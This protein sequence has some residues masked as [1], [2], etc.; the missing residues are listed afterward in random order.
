MSFESIGLAWPYSLFWLLVGGLIYFLCLFWHAGKLFK[1][2]TTKEAWKLTLLRAL[3]GLFFIL[4]VARP[5]MDNLKTNPDAVRIVSLI[6]LS[7]SMNQRDAPTETRRIELVQPWFNLERE[8][9]WINKLR[10]RFGMVDRLGFTHDEVFKVRESSWALPEMGNNTSLGDAL[11]YIIESPDLGN[12]GAVV[13]FSD[14]RNN[15]G[16]SPLKTGEIF[17][18]RGIPVNIIGVGKDRDL[19][20]ISVA[21]ADIPTDVN[22][23]EELII[24]AEIQNSFQSEVSTM[25][26]LLVN[27]LE[28]ESLSVS[29]G[30]GESRTIRFPPLI[31]EVP[32]VFTYRVLV[33]PLDGDFDPSDDEDAQL[34]QVRPPS[35]FSALYLSHQ[36]RPLYPFLKRALSNERFQLSSLIRLGNETFHARGEKILPTGYPNNP[37]FWMDY[38]VVLVD[39]G[40]LN[41][42]NGTLVT[43]L[44]D[45]VQKRGGGL[46]LLGDPTPAQQ[47]LGGLMPVKQTQSAMAKEDLSLSVSPD[48]LF[49]E[50]K[51]LDEWKTFL[52]GGMPAELITRTNPAAR[53]VVNLR[54][55]S[56]R[57][58]LTIQAYGAG[59]SAYWGSPHDW[60][61]SLIN[62][63]RSREFSL[64]WSG[65]VEWLGSGSVE[66]IKVD[67]Q[68]KPGISG[69]ANLLTIDV[70]GQ[71]FEPSMDARVE[72]NITGPDGFSKFL[73]LY[74]EGLSLGRYGGEFIPQD[75]GSYQ[76]LYKLS[77]PD[78]EKIEHMSYLKVKPSGDESK[79]TRY[80]ERDLQMLANLTGGEF[81]KV[82]N[83]SD[84]W[85]PRLSSALPTISKRSNLADAWP[86][87][88]VLFMAAG[89]EWIIRRKGGLK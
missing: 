86:L 31:P 62:E 17:R 85:M 57:A 10:T 3:S 63:D 77:Y 6:D 58:I 26:R 35:F 23:K 22:A 41:E 73:Q 60:K 20:N 79:D 64:F 19:G 33:D 44:K 29:L 56:D 32:G 69:E 59:K 43:S 2:T 28:L 36:V 78:G 18:E 51:R 84:D 76:V 15:K 67:Q 75:A 46:L 54:G 25:V 8:N 61:R 83:M 16:V 1:S 66:R 55:S 70:L 82:E 27:D 42:L 5:F 7:G 48:P 80:A 68:E 45:F 13:L 9:S 37:D 21:F 11:T 24:S 52:P 50:L 38:D 87:F 12:V 88:L 14:G 81:L 34:I 53:D 74:P 71:D 4:L 72:A 89:M 65:I 40:C 47:L 30:T 39:S 49:T